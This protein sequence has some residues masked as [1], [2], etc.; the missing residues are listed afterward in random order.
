MYLCFQKYSKTISLFYLFYLVLSCL[1]PHP[2]TKLVFCR[3]ST[4]QTCIVS[5]R[6]HFGTAFQKGSEAIGPLRPKSNTCMP[7]GT[8][9]QKGSETIG[10]LSPRSNT[11]MHFA[12]AFQKGSEAIGPLSSKSNTCMHFGTTF[13]KGLETIG[14]MNARNN[15]C[16]HLERRSK[17]VRRPSAR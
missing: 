4:K 9:F 10:P 15:T 8:A 3:P 12:T 1:T 16:M 7:F 2:Q 14:P 5:T 17:K 11:C 13:Q 6:V